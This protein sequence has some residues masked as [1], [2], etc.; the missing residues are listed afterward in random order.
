MSYPN[1]FDYLFY[2]QESSA[3]IYDLIHIFRTIIFVGRQ[4]GDMFHS[5]PV[6]VCE[7]TT[8]GACLAAENKTNYLN[9]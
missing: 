9:L 6:C 1:E 3:S 7:S 5:L 4:L 2:I 8:Q